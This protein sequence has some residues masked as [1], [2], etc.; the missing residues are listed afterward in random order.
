MRRIPLSWALTSH[1]VGERE[2]L[3]GM[4]DSLA[5]NALLI[6][7]RGCPSDVLLGKIFASARPFVVRM[8]A[9]G[10]AWR[11]VSDFLASGKRDLCPG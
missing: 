11:E 9:S 10:T 3:L 1:T 8:V 4:L 2:T 6:L 5:H 7:D